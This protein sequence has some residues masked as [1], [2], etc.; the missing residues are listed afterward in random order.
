[1]KYG[2]KEEMGERLKDIRSYFDLTQ[3]EMAD[4]FGMSQPGY[5]FYE[6][7]QRYFDHEIL[8]ILKDAFGVRPEWMISGTGDRFKFNS[9]T[10]A[11][12]PQRHLIDLIGK[13]D[14]DHLHMLIRYAEDIYS[15]QEKKR[16]GYSRKRKEA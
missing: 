8:E 2:N 13:L 9:G 3:K 4:Y 1:M 5:S 15:L 7:G 14:A 6:K 12:T 10:V 16:S 11:T